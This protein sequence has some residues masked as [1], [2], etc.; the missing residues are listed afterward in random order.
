V[1]G[2]GSEQGQ[3]SLNLPAGA[4]RPGLSPA[5][6]PDLSGTP[7]AAR[8]LAPGSQAEKLYVQGVSAT[9]PPGRF[10]DFRLPEPAP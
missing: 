1:F 7:V 9:A 8:E 10:D 6:M 4:A 2:N 5:A 3:I